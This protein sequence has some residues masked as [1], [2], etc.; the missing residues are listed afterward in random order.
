MK[1]RIHPNHKTKHCVKNWARYE[2]GLV[3][4]GDITVWLSPAAVATWTPNSGN[5]PCGQRRFSD[6]AI[7]IALTVRSVFGL[8]L[9]Q[10]EGFLRSLFGWMGLNFS[11]PDHTTLFRR[12]NELGVRLLR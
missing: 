7:E 9:R 10:A 2:R 5:R 3:Q 11:V 6:L 8:R 1:S 12:S 4:R